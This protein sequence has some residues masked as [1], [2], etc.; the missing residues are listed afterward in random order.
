MYN[1]STFSF[2]AS[3]LKIAR[4]WGVTD[5][6]NCNFVRSDM[7]SITIF[8][9]ADLFNK[10]KCVNAQSLKPLFLTYPKSPKNKVTETN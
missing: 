4:I 1:T 9:I 5:F 7:Y 3:L 2:E 10:T 6:G 8:I